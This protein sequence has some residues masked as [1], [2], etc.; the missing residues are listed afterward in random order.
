MWASSA[1]FAFWLSRSRRFP[2]RPGLLAAGFKGPFA[3]RTALIWSTI[4]GEARLIDVAAA[5]GPDEPAPAAPVSAGAQ[6]PPAAQAAPALPAADP[7]PAPKRLP[8]KPLFGSVKA[9]CPACGE[10]RPH[11]KSGVCA[12]CGLTNPWLAEKWKIKPAKDASAAAPVQ[13]P[14]EPVVEDAAVLSSAPSAA[15]EAPQVSAPAGWDAAPDGLGSGGHV[16]FTP[17]SEQELLAAP[18]AP[19][20]AAPSPAPGI[21]DTAAPAP[22]APQAGDPLAAGP[23]PASGAVPSLGSGDPLGAPA[24][25]DV[26]AAG[27]IPPASPIPEAEPI[28]PAPDIPAPEEIAPS[29]GDLP[30]PSLDFEDDSWD[31]AAAG[32]VVPLPDTWEDED[33]PPAPEAASPAPEAPAPAPAP[34]QPGRCPGCGRPAM[35]DHYGACVFCGAGL[36]GTEA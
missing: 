36:G 19:E 17:A 6:G 4:G 23:R 2:D 10:K 35:P 32:P 33:L 13:L 5:S 12:G 7:G 11:G 30:A 29:G 25:F 3:A 8:G 28:P 14:D 24:E 9:P 22:A 20:A 18:A 15:D 16:P 21:P 31:A 26:P 27:P 34:A 1:A